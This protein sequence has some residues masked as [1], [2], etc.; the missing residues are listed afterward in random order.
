MPNVKV[1]ERCT[2]M[3]ANLETIFTG[4]VKLYYSRGFYI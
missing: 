4:T 1:L 3:T 2:E